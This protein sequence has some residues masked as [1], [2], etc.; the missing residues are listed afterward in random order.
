MRLVINLALGKSL[1]RWSHSIYS[2]VVSYATTDQPQGLAEL[3]KNF[4]GGSPEI[5][6]EVLE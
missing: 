2:Y 5:A 3:R 4:M 1:E 6:W